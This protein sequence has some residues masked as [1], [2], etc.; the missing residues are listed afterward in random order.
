M[1]GSLFLF[2]L[3][4]GLEVVHEVLDL[5]DLGFSVGVDNL[6]KVLHESKV[7][8]HC[9]S[10][11]SDLAK[12]RNESDL[13]SSSAIFVDQEGLVGVLDLLVVL[14]LVVLGVAGLST[15]LIEASQGGLR[16]VDSIDLVC[17]LVIRGHDSGT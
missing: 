12:F 14:G 17:L 13:E 1:P 4:V 8:T 5:L 10:Q 16:K 15:L 7:S 2:A 9:I 3:L 11:T 6:S